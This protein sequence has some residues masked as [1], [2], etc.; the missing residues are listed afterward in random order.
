MTP[1][2]SA[3]SRKAILIVD[4]ELDIRELLAFELDRL[5]YDVEVAEHGQAAVEAAQRRRFDLAITDL[6]MP[7]M[8]G[9][10]TL[11]ALKAIDP[12]IAVL[13]ATGYATEEIEDECRSGG[14]CGTLRKPFDLIDLFE[15]I[16]D[17]LSARS[18]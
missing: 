2:M 18:G 12:S 15:L 17:R 9:I 4:D 16:A 5:G 8:G 1:M 11:R 7:V 6:K 3:P 13:I 14:A 10:E